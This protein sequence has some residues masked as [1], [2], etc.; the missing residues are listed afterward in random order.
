MAHGGFQRGNFRTDGLL[1]LGEAA[2]HFLVEHD[3]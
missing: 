2:L 3:N 1:D